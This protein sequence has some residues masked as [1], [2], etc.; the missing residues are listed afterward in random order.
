MRIRFY[1]MSVDTGEK[2]DF[3]FD[4]K[5]DNMIV[6]QVSED[7]TRVSNGFWS[8]DVWTETMVDID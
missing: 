1:A 8:Y 2:L 4:L 7:V 6:E 3:N 5:K